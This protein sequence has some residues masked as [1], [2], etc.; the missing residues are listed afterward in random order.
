MPRSN[1]YYDDRQQFYQAR[2]NKRRQFEDPANAIVKEMVGSGTNEP[3]SYDRSA[4]SNELMTGEFGGLGYSY[5]QPKG[6]KRP[7]GAYSMADYPYLHHAI[8]VA[9]AGMPP[10][11]MSGGVIPGS[12]KDLELQEQRKRWAAAQEAML[13]K[14]GF[15]NHYDW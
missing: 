7:E 1:R 11:Q 9:K 13:N 12:K 10:A 5:K 4:A 8:W 2:E 15:W 3:G 14:D 6:D